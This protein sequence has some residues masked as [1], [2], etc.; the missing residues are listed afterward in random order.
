M[1]AARRALLVLVALLT[2]TTPLHAQSIGGPIAVTVVDSGTACVTAP[3]ACATFTLDST[4][5]SVSL[6]VSGTWTG[7]LTFEGS[8]NGSVWTTVLGADLSTLGAAST[9][10]ANGTFGFAN[11]GLVKIRARATAAI[12]GTAVLTAA[13][14]GGVGAANAGASANVTLAAETTKVIG[15]VRVKGNLGAAFDAA[16]AAAPP[17]NAIQ[18]AGIGSGA[19]GGFLIGVAVADTFKNVNISTNTTTLLITGVAGRHIR[20][21]SFDLLTVLANNVGIIS[22]TG[23]TCGTGSAAIVGTTAATG[24]NLA[25]AGRVQAGSGVGTVLQTVAA[26]DSICLITSAATQLS[27]IWAYAIY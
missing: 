22:G 8:N 26:G 2:C 13:R 3:T 16:I 6:N 27:G 10:T 23:A 25:A 17:A 1:T 12:T 20:V 11:A 7:T 5:N 24:Y 21:S 18:I 19:T 9:T 4:T 14:G 15:T